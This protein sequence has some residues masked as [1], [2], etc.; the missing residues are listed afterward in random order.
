VL[1]TELLLQ[2]LTDDYSKEEQGCR[3]RNWDILDTGSRT[4]TKGCVIECLANVA[5][6]DGTH[7]IVRATLLVTLDS[8]LHSWTAIKHDVNERGIWQDIGNSGEGKEFA[9]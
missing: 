7:G 1:I 4:G 6:I 3:Q 5:R 9:Q 2:F 8:V